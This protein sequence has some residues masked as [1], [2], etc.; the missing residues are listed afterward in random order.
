LN[1]LTPAAHAAAR[2]RVAVE[3]VA[4]YERALRRTARRYS[5]CADDAEDAL[6]RALEILM[7]KAPPGEARDLIRWMQTVTKH[8]AL[9][10]RRSRER[11]LGAP[12]P[13]ADG[14]EETVDWISLIPASSEG[15]EEA[16]EQ[17]EEM[18]R[19]REALKTLKPAELRALTLLAEGYSYA[20]I[21]RLTG[22]SRTKVNRCL[23]EGRERF[24]AFL[25]RSESGD[26]CAE[27]R[28]ILS[29]F[30]DGEADPAEVPMLREH[31][32]ACAHCRA[33][34]RAYRAAPGAAA[35]APLPFARSLLE[36]A[37]QALAGLQARLHGPR[38]AT[39]NAI[40]Q[41]AAS[42]GGRGAGLAGLTKAVAV[43]AATAG[44]AAACVGAGFVPAP[45]GLVGDAPASKPVSSRDAAAAPASRPAPTS[46]PL[47]D[48]SPTRSPEPA[49]T[50]REPEPSTPPAE[51]EAVPAEAG[52]IEYA[53]E[54]PASE[55]SSAPTPA[56]APAPAP[57]E[58]GTGAGGAAGEFG[59]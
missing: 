57:S 35:L 25:S 19:S 51:Q 29:A 48:P 43:C 10:I 52:A 46:V 50:H 27:L 16:A 49:D 24:R 33:A 40:G 5:I 11:Q 45:L 21:G 15:P 1:G 28:P 41:A 54:A 37:H 7:L 58:A 9:A 47:P 55:P 36:R 13:R 53:P 56:P 26:R 44:G 38:A 59:P 30:C 42:G 23:A 22:Y 12:R 34:M 2:K 32:R 6:Q 8:E 18:A 4:K 31:L 14:Q 3:M 20:E 17:R 39:E